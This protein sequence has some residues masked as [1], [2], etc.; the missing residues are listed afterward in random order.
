VPANYATYLSMT[1]N[2]VYSYSGR[3]GSLCTKYTEED[4]EITER[5]FDAT[6]RTLKENDL[7]GRTS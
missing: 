3:G 7:I 1:N 6:L 2:G 4:L 5:A